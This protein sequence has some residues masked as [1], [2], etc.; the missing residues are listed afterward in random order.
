MAGDLIQPSSKPSAPPKLLAALE[1]LRT[2]AH[3]SKSGNII[4]SQVIDLVSNLESDNHTVCSG[5]DSKTSCTIIQTLLEFH[6]CRDSE[7]GI[8]LLGVRASNP[9]DFLLLTPSL[10][11]P[12]L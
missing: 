9:F 4:K 6:G 3:R 5:I 12:V 1:K 11:C 10:G 2:K 7:R 8:Y